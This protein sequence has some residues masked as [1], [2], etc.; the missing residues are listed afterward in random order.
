LN[1]PGRATRRPSKREINLGMR[2]Y[3]VLYVTM[4]EASG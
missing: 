1:I 4:E 2:S 3:T